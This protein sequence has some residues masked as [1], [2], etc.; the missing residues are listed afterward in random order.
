MWYNQRTKTAVV[1]L[2]A[3]NLN[4]GELSKQMIK[5]RTC[6]PDPQLCRRPGLRGCTHFPPTVLNTGES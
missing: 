1:I 5:G 3:R 6:V 2:S 4:L